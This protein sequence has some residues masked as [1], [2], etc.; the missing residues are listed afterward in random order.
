M[1]KRY[2][3]LIVSL[4]VI[5][6]ITYYLDSQKKENQFIVETERELDSLNK[7]KNNTFHLAD[8]VLNHFDEQKKKDEEKLSSLDDMVKNNQITIEQQ[9]NELKR[10]VEESNKMKSLAEKSLAESEKEKAIKVERMAKEQQ[11]V[12]EQQRMKSEMVL[13][14]IQKTNKRLLDLNNKL[15]KENEDL[16]N[17]I[18]NLRNTIKSM[19]KK[20][21]GKN[22]GDSKSKK[23]NRGEN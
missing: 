4:S 1:K 7:E 15:T 17:K 22:D 18:T 8:E 21:Y 6:S 13:D 10:L 20:M 19:E 23:K 3:F 14:S 11:M 12:A 16:K 2:I 5:G 9:V